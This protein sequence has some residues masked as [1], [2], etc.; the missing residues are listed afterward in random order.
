MLI[1]STILAPIVVGC[2]LAIFNHWL[3]IRRKKTKRK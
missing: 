1:F 2:V 3:E